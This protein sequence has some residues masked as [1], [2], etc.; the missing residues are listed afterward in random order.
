MPVR[1]AVH[2]HALDAAALAHGHHHL[3]ALI[4]RTQKPRHRA[5][6]A[7]TGHAHFIAVHIGAILQVIERAHRIPH[8]GAGGRVATARPV[9]AILAV[10][11][12]MQALAFAE[13]DR[14]EHQRHIT[15]LGKPA[16]VRLIG[17]VHL[18][19][20]VAAK[21]KNGGQPAR[22]LRGAVKIA[23]HMSAGHTLEMDLLHHVISALQHAGHGGL[24][25]GAL[26]QW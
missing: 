21:I 18:A 20:R 14:V 12:M 10:G 17:R 4:R 2:R 1:G 6:A 16:R 9:P 5:A 26:R 22:D 25:G 19:L 3:H 23:G 7:E 8:L 15:M 11:A 24:Q 13:L